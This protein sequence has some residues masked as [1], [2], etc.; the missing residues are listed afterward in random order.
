MPLEP[1]DLKRCQAEY[2]RNEPFRL[3][4]GMRRVRCENAATQIAIE[5]EAGPDGLNGLMSMCDDCRAVFEKQGGAD[6]A[7]FVPVELFVV[8]PR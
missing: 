8:E 5:K 6:T 4:G 1:P 7:V 3:G 2:T